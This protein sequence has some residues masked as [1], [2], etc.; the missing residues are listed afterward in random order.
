MLALP[1][2]SPVRVAVAL[3]AALF[4][5]V[6]AGPA[7]ADDGRA[8]LKMAP[9]DSTL[10]VSVDLEQLRKHP[11]YPAAVA[12]LTK[13]ESTRRGFEELRAEVGL[14][15]HQ[16]LRSLTIVMPFTSGGAPGD[17]L[18]FAR[19]KI[20]G[21]KLLAFSD[22]R[23][24]PSTA[25]EHLGQAWYEIDGGGLLFVGDHAVAGNTPAIQAAIAAR[26]PK[27]ASLEKNAA[28][29]K[30]VKAVDTKADAWFAMLVPKGMR[31]E[32]GRD[33]PLYG[34]FQSAAGSFDLGDGLKVR[35]SLGA[36]DAKSAVEMAEETRKGLAEAAAD[37]QMRL[38]GFASALSKVQVT[39]K[40]AQVELALDLTQ[41]ELD[42]LVKKLLVLL[43]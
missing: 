23:G 21:P 22:K 16:D 28:M 30:L 40:R 20:D 32:M 31:D 12:E 1:L 6:A 36:V 5:F 13:D 11:A 4:V 34:R 15:V 3:A 8:A 19:G 7:V 14:D 41:E 25:R 33:N 38:M 35:L 42:P 18:I 37:P 27:G 29:M 17:A 43:R 10:V 39:T 2:R 26:A 24:A 9:R